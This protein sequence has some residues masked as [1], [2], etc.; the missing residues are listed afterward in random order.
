M[1]ITVQISKR[2]ELR[3]K[4]VMLILLLKLHEALNQP[5]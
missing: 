3:K 1:E 4:N 5:T 2:R